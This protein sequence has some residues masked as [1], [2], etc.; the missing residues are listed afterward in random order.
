MFGVIKKTKTP[1]GARLL[2][3]NLLRPCTDVATIE[4]RLRLV[5][6]FLS[7]V[8]YLLA[9]RGDYVRFFKLLVV[10]C[11]KKQGSDRS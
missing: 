4:E 11:A 2:R 9:E 8:S 6:F 7:H 5:D 1:V 3:S 10:A